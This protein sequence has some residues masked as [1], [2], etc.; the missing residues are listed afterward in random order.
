MVF[1]SQNT[2]FLV[3]HFDFPLHNFANCCVYYLWCKMHFG[4]VSKKNS[5]V[6]C[7]WQCDFQIDTP[8]PSNSVHEN[9]EYMECQH[10]RVSL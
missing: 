1:T 3:A 9:L 5:S 6:N 2:T 10:D 8:F 7:V 4:W